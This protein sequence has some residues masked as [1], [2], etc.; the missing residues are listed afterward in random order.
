LEVVVVLRS[1]SKELIFLRLS[2][3]L[4]VYDQ[5]KKILHPCNILGGEEVSIAN[6]QTPLHKCSGWGFPLMVSE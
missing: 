6:P 1:L 5:E 2:V 4:V 3:T